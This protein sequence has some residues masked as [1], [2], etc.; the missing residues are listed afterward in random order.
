M[1]IQK[2]N[3]DQKIKWKSA[4]KDDI[5]KQNFDEIKKAIES[6]YKIIL[7]HESAFPLYLNQDKYLL[8][9]LKSISKEI[10][11]ITG[12]LSLKDGHT[13]NSSYFFK[14]GKLEVANK[15]VLVPFGEAIPLPNW[16]KKI[17][18]NLFFNGADDYKTDSRPTDFN[19]NNVKIRNAI[20][21]EATSKELYENN[22]KHMVVLSNNAWF[23]PSIEPTLQNMLLRLFSQRYGTVIYHSANIDKS[24]VI[25]PK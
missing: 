22:P 12:A 10:T 13:Y 17:I 2:P 4:H 7:L 6:G 1:Y 8:Q 18:N 16:A 23:T 21:Y 9:K 20:C 25:I 3:L 14:D 24:G 19:V 5:I 11:I 15:V